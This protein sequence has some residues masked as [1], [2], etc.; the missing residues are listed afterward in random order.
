MNA[1]RVKSCNRTLAPS[2]CFKQA[3][4]GSVDTSPTSFT[5]TSAATPACTCLHAVRP[6]HRYVLLFVIRELRVRLTGRTRQ[7]RLTKRQLRP[8]PL[9]P[10]VTREYRDTLIEDRVLRDFST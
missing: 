10:Q 1:N 8:A 3:D 5:N 4:C 9:F 7:A 2:A 6:I